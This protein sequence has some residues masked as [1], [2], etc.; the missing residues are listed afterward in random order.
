[1]PSPSVHKKAS[2]PLGETAARTYESKLKMIQSYLE[3]GAS[4]RLST[5]S[6][7]SEIVR[8]SQ[9]ITAS[10]RNGCKLL[11]FGNGG[12]AADAQHIAAEFTGRFRKDRDALPA[13]ALATNA[14]EV[15]AIANDYGFENV[16][17][18]QVR[19]LAKPADTVMGISTSGSSRNVL[20]G[21]ATA[22]QLQAKTIG[23]TG[24][25]GDMALFSDILIP[26]PSD[27]TSLLQEVHVA[28]GH[29][30]CMLV[31]EELFG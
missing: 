12:S 24:E 26:V 7:S 6:V 29:L 20:N 28:I 8:A 13:I 19:A 14:S 21:L 27:K 2:S 25:K 31:E 22:R 1:M 15:T 5:L 3:E 16:L 17:S 18:R 9:A 23:L 30:L 10:F 4:I 11:T